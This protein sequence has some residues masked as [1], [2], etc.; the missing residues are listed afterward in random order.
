MSHTKD[1]PPARRG[2]ARFLAALPAV[3]HY[4]G[5]DF[6]CAADDLSRSGVLLAGKVPIPTAPDVEITISTPTGDRRVRVAGRLAHAHPDPESGE[7][8]LGVHFEGL[9]DEQYEVIDLIVSRVVEGMA[10]ASLQ[11][12]DPRASLGEIRE[13]LGKITPAHRISLA[14][15]CGPKE[16]AILKHDPDPHVLE[17][18]ARNPNVNLPELKSLL[19][20][21]DL[22]P[23]TLEIVAE[24]VRWRGD[25]ELKILI[26]THHRVTFT[27]ADKV[28]KRLNDLAIGRLIQRPGLHP[29]VKQK[30]MA[31]LAA[32]NRG[33]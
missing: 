25:E 8:H 15:R 30:L 26:A 20:R 14:G 4:D 29:G 32:K 1:E 10:P 21:S 2:K 3:L 12:I 17:A 24:D 16:R 9:S 18:L 6:D 13:A 5:R 22:L 33:G 11:G 7:T 23:S 28:V 31:R 19:R 27:T